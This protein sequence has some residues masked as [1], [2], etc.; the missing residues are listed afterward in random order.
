MLRRSLVVLGL[1]AMFATTASAQTVDD[2]IAKS[3]AA[4]GGMDK[5]KAI[6]TVRMTGKMTVGPGFEAPVT[7]EMRR[8]NQT[9]MQ[10]TLQGM[11]GTQAYDGKNGWVVMP[12]TGKKEPEAM[13]DDDKKEIADEADIDG[14]LVDYKSKGNIVELLGKEPIEGTDA[15]KLKVTLKSGTVRTIYI[16]ADSY[17]EIK[18]EGKRTVRGTEMEFEGTIGDYK[19]VEG[20]LFPFSLENSVKGHA[21]KQKIT[22]EK[23]EINPTLS[24]DNF[25]MPAK[26]DSAAAA[27]AKVG[28]SKAEVKAEPAKADSKTAAANAST[29]TTTTKKSAKKPAT[30]P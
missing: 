12:F 14:P 26:S 18:S 6:Q 7:M 19:P 11:T 5:I 8:P 10:F 4:R 25:T 30:K 21:E 15:Y 16:D 17:L 29:K 24:A 23:V 13:S 2:I 22:F 3:V 1:I 9:K 27:T 20:V 28:D